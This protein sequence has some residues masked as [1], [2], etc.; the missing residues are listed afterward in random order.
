MAPQAQDFIKGW[1]HPELLGGDALKHSL[2]ESFKKGLEMS[3]ESLNYGDKENG[4]Y[5]LGH[6]KFRQGLAKFL[7]GQYGTPVDWKTLMSTAGSSMGTDLALRVHCK[8]GDICVVEEPTYFLAFTMARNRDMQLKGVPMQPDGMDLD[9]LE[10]VLEESGGKV[11]MVYTVPVHHNPTGITM[12]N[13]KRVRLVALAKKYKFLIAADEAYQLLNFTPA[14]VKPLFYHDDPADPRVLSIGTFSKLIGPGTKVG[15]VQAHES[16]LKP[17][18]SIGFIDSG[19]NPVIFSSM[20]LLHFIESGALAKHIDMV[21]K[22]LG[23]RCKLICRKL[24]EVGLEVVEPKGGYFVW[25]ESKGKMTGRSG[26]VA[27][28]NKDKFAKFMRLCFCW[29]TRSQIEEG[30]EF[31]RP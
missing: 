19:N 10:K 9:A 30:I 29:L 27:S 26:E 12:S 3:T 25:V 22:D 20:N 18:Q 17:L 4:A 6:P 24:K 21:S 23:D 8:A 15:W 14:E 28:I 5:M 13:A 16:L 2:L 31:L 7:E 1:P 11:K